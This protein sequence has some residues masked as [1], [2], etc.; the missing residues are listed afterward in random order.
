MQYVY[1]Y[2]IYIIIYISLQYV[3]STP[4]YTSIACMHACST[5]TYIESNIRA[6]ENMY[7]YNLCT[8]LMTDGHYS[9]TYVQL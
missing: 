4:T 2:V 1:V 9:C 7:S 3:C 5:P 8:A 6:C